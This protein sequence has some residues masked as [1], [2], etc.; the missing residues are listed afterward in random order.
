MC[1]TEL[2]AAPPEL[3]EDQRDGQQRGE[4]AEKPTGIRLPTHWVGH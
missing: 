1:G 4:Q 3:V 2:E